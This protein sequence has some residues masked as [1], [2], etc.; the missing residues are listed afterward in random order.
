MMQ[1]REP[2]I[3][4]LGDI[5]GGARLSSMLRELVATLLRSG[6]VLLRPQV[7]GIIVP[8]D[9]ADSSLRWGELNRIFLE[10]D[11]TVP[12]PR[13]EAA[14]VGIAV[15]FIL[16]NAPIYTLTLAPSGMGMD[17][18]QAPLIDGAAS[19]NLNVAGLYS[20]KNDGQNWFFARSP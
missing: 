12:L 7:S 17:R 14:M 16:L 8:R 13:I 18:Q 6:L 11:S 2:N 19:V 20:L 1:T 10:Q 5:P 4:E 15:E 9:G 3:P